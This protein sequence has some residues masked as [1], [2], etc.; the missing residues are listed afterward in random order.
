[1]RLLITCH[2]LEHV[3]YISDILDGVAALLVPDGVA[4][5]EVPNLRL[6]MINGHF[7]SMSFQHE[8]LFTVGSL[9]GELQ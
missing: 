9:V 5:I 8:V 1:M 4:V 6:Q 2:T 7:E 3:F